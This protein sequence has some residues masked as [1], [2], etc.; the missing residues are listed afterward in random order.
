M[1]PAPA[2]NRQHATG[3]VLGLATGEALAL[4]YVSSPEKVDKGVTMTSGGDWSE[5][6]W[7]PS[8]AMA[9]AVLSAMNEAV[10]YNREKWADY[11]AVR[12]V[13][14]AHSEGK[15]LDSRTRDLLRSVSRDEASEEALASRAK[16]SG[17]AGAL[18]VAHVAPLA[19]LFLGDD[20]EAELA[21]A[22]DRLARMTHPEEDAREAAVLVALMMQQAA[23]YGSV[24]IEEQIKY[25]PTGSQDKWE[26]LLKEGGDAASFN[27][28][29]VKSSD[30]NKA[31]VAVLQSAVAA[32][33][34]RSAVENVLIQAVRS[35][36]NAHVAAVAGALTGGDQGSREL[37]ATWTSK[38]HGENLHGEGGAVR[39][40][41]KD[42][43]NVVNRTYQSDPYKVD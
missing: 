3:S 32:F 16:A 36:A 9:L 21:K 23:R 39:A 20:Q 14:W 1:A 22:A 43:E 8:T 5:G 27:S 11:L 29:H 38:L 25:L 18:P 33:R 6:E 15:G 41:T 31:S 28:I 24:S 37:P 34:S 7:G 35:T 2:F 19:L 42:V 26:Q 13:E 10:I 4:P 30:A 40:I 17:G 12:W